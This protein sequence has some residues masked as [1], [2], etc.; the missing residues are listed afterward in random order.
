M[1]KSRFFALSVWIALT[2]CNPD[3]RPEQVDENVDRVPV[4][5]NSEQPVPNIRN[6]ATKL[7]LHPVVLAPAPA[8]HG[9]QASG[10]EPGGQSIPCGTCHTTR[11]PD[12]S[13][14]SGAALDEF[15]VGLTYAHGGQACVSCHDPDDYSKLRLA[16]GT[17]VDFATPMALCAQCH[18][19][20]KR[21][22]D[23]GSH[24]GWN[25]YWDLTR[26]PRTRNQCTHCHDPHAPAYPSMQ[27]TFKPRDRFLD[28]ETQHGESH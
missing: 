23:N 6:S 17:N 5:G 22:Y 1:L 11:E 18:G 15:H 28:D 10:S 20:Q 2:G 16:D 13:T 8:P 14:R 24:G 25:G 27:P 9:V 4:A 21:D 19:T 3:V 7:P 12:R 26:G